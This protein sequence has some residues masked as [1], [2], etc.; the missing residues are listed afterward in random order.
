LLTLGQSNGR[1]LGTLQVPDQPFTLIYVKRPTAMAPA[2][3][4]TIDLQG[5]QPASLVYFPDS[6]NNP[7]SADSKGK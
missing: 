4:V 6:T 3:V 7:V 2:T 5:K 1:P